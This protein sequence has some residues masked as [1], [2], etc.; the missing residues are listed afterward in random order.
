MT[1]T[2]Q[3]SNGGPMTT[4]RILTTLTGAALIAASVTAAAIPASASATPPRCSAYHLV[5]ALEDPVATGGNTGAV[6]VAGNNGRTACTVSGYPRLGLTRHGRH[7]PSATTDGATYFQPDPGPSVIVLPPHATAVA[8]VGYGTVSG[9]GNVRA[10]RLTVR[11][12]G[13]RWGHS[14]RL[15]GAPTAI[16]N[17][18]LTVTA[19]AIAREG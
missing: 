19:W 6:L 9:T 8:Y 16:T 4:A 17:G 11:I 18:V 7:V 1:I 10:S 2:A 3:P 13:A 12:R 5:T 15:P 14:V